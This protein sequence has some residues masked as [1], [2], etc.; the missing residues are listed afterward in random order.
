MLLGLEK[1]ALN[2]MVEQ[3]NPDS[4]EQNEKETVVT[5]ISDCM[6]CQNPEKTCMLN[7]VTFSMGEDGTF[8]CGQ[9]SQSQPQEEIQGQQMPAQ[10]EM[11]G[12]QT[13]LAKV[14]QPAQPTQQEAQPVGLAKVKGV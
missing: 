10:P 4:E 8:S 5:C 1:L 7:N 13:G 3:S 11:S 14:K 6:Y 9:Y 12:A 2:E